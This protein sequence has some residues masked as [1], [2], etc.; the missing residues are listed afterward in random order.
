VIAAHRTIAVL[1]SAQRQWLE[2]CALDPATLLRWNDPSGGFVSHTPH[3]V[4]CWLN[5][6]SAN[7]A[8]VHFSSACISISDPANRR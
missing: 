2:L 3:P 7:N 8:G 6:S 5:F 1:N 4:F